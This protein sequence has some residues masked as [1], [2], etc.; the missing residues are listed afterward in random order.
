MA[1]D[2]KIKAIAPWFG[3]KRNLAPL[4]VAELGDH[5]AY[6]E[7][8]CGSMAVLMAK[9]K[10]AMET[11][12]D[13][14]AGLVNFARVI[15]DPQRG[16]KLYRM[17]RRTLMTEEFFQD[18]DWIVRNAECDRW[19][20]KLLNA[21]DWPEA[22]SIEAAYN[23]FLVSW[24]G[25]SGAAGTPA[26]RKGTYC[27]RYTQNGGHAATRF[28]SA[29]SSIP[30]WRR[31]LANV[32]IL[33]REGLEIIERIDDADGT[34]IYCDPPYLVKGSSYLHDFDQPDHD[35][36]ASLLARFRKARVV[37]SY[38]DHPKLAELYSRW[39]RVEIEVS[40]AMSHAGNRGAN[41]TKA[42]EVLLING[43]SYTAS[44]PTP[45]LFEAEAGQ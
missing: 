41:Q 29:I 36:L 20:E 35:R 8:F 16:P 9:P 26:S 38:Y 14:H 27:C 28:N 5:R 13:L 21:L 11:V 31:R 7:P 15:R 33:N 39:T 42:T 12:N 2:M 23:Y 3:G 37:V 10:C 1:D 18:A 22:D 32:T 19:Y 25:R 30:A 6:W 40:K 24:L 45:Q 44:L 43:P 17:L 34:A 4:I